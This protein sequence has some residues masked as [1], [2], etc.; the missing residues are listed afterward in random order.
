MRRGDVLARVDTSRLRPQVDLA[1]AQAMAQQQVVARFHHGSRPE[2]IAQARANVDSA[3]ADD[4]NAR[5]QYA[6]LKSLSDVTGAMGRVVSLQDLDNAKA[7]LDTAAARLEV[8]QKALD[9][10]VAGPRREDV[11]EADATL[12]AN[13][14]QAALLQQELADAQLKAPLDAVVRTRIMEPGEMASPQRPVFSLAIVDPKWVRAYVSEPDLGKVRPGMAAGVRVDSFSGRRFEGWVGFISPVAEFT[15][16]SVEM[17]ELRTSLVYEVRVFVKDPDDELRL[18]MPATVYLSLEKPDHKLGDAGDAAPAVRANAAGTPSIPDA[19][20]ATTT[21]PA[22]AQELE[23]GNYPTPRCGQQV[24]RGN[25]VISANHA[26]RR[27]AAMT[28]AATS[29][30]VLFGQ[31]IHK[32]F[33]RDNGEIVR[34]LDGVSVRAEHG[35]LTALGRAGWRRQDNADPVDDRFADRGF[36]RT[37]G[38][39]YRYCR[40]SAAG[41]EPHWLHA[42]EI[43]VV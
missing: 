7:A 35:T 5:R 36:R 19:Q 16:K 10:E 2:E 30:L 40:R 31:D 15:P 20:P 13:Q 22:Q 27:E 38:F 25:S 17:E 8:N 32:T 41:A 4:A 6:R 39:G 18:G 43:R 37:K 12:R 33:R 21:A 34:A 23:Q 28:A 42:P 9:L 1:Q 24:T 26:Q 29:T 11:A 3:K 14:A